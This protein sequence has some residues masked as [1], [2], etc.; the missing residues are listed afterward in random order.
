[1]NTLPPSVFD[2]FHSAAK[3]DLRV[4]EIRLNQRTADHA[5]GLIL[6]FGKAREDMVQLVIMQALHQ[7]FAEHGAVVGLGPD[8]RILVQLTCS[9]VR[10]VIS[11]DFPVQKDVMD[12]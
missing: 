4:I 8:V 7:H 5:Q 10:A 1:M 9:Q 11:F 3:Y 2:L 6:L 12:A